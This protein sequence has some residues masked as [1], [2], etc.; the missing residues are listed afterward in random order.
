M[1]KAAR[2]IVYALILMTSLGIAVAQEDSSSSSD[3]P[4]QSEQTQPFQGT[5]PEGEPEA[6]TPGPPSDSASQESDDL[7]G[8]A[9]ED[10]SRAVLDQTIADVAFT[11][12]D[13]DLLE[14]A[15][16][17]AGLG[18]TL[19]GEG[20]FTVFAPSDLAFAR[21]GEQERTA[22]F[23][24]TAALR[25]LLLYHVADRLIF[26]SELANM[27]T[28]PTA[29]DNVSITGPSVRQAE[30]GLYIDTARVVRSDVE[31]LNGIIHVIDTVLMPPELGTPSG[32]END[33]SSS[34]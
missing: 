16:V 13:F 1:K 32:S 33:S 15:L 14:D 23:E 10:E 9:Q 29:A 3:D 19:A 21:L 34:D 7:E 12:D 8:D 18:P 30:G 20:P 6:E 27:D 22:L 25:R 24:D 4:A 26:E 17:A 11:S 28:V 5:P 2:T 31:T